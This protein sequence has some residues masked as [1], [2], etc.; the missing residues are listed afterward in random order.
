[1]NC[2]GHSGKDQGIK[3]LLSIDEL[4]EFLIVYDSCFDVQI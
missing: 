3:L 2:S 1:M 4:P